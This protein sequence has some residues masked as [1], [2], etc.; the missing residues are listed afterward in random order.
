MKINLLKITILSCVSLILLYYVLTL[1]H[2]LDVFIYVFHLL[3]PVI[4]ALLMNF[5]LEPVI[6]YFCSDRLKRK[7]VV[8]YLYLIFAL[9]F[10]LACYF[11]APYI[12]QQ[13]MS[14]YHEYTKGNIHFHPIMKTIYQFLE[15]YQII[16]ELMSILNGWTQSFLYW[17][18]QILLSFGISFYLSY[19]HIHLIEKCIIYLP[20]VH[21]GICMQT[22]KRLQIVTYQ[23]MKSMFL[24]F[25]FFFIISAV[26][27]FFIDRQLM[28]WMALFLSMTNLIP[29]VGP[30]IGGVPI[31]IYEYMQNTQL[32]YITL[33]AII[34]LQY[35]ESSY[36]QPYLFSKGI[37]LHPIALFVALTFFGDSFGLIGMIFSPLFLSYVFI[38]FRL[39]KELKIFHHIKIFL[40]QQEY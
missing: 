39:L 17:I 2:V 23:F 5:L 24:D 20:F 31:V 8:I 16:N 25:L 26:V 33:V 9:V 35:I 15:R 19:D 6:D 28:L 22:L 34:V 38:I 11:V 21:Q 3:L 32:G 36:L 10:M 1:W 12:L 37:Q 18:G 4:I 40:K 27:F 30:Y 29:Y 13:C 14:F 7:Y